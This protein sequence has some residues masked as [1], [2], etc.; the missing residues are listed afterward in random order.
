M[1]SCKAELRNDPRQHASVKA[2]L[3][4]AARLDT[5]LVENHSE[6]TCSPE[7]RYLSTVRGS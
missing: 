1:Q 2:M 6:D 7:H 5:I 3:T 4:M